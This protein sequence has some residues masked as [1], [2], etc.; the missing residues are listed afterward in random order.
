MKKTKKGQYGYIKYQKKIEIVKTI[1]MILLSVGVY[2]IGI[3]STGSNENLLTFVAVLGCLP[4]AKFCVNAIMF[5]RAKGCS[6]E[7]HE[8]LMN[9][10]LNPLYFDLYFTSAK[11]NFQVSA[12]EYKKKSLIMISEDEKID[13]TKAEEHIKTVLANCG[14]SGVTV[15]LFIEPE[16]FVQRLKELNELESDKEDITVLSDNILSVSI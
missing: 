1:F 15:K 7:L 12:L 10:N 8:R 2:R 16:K 13:V 11:S 5:S 9:E 14:Y 3:Y 4:M 6:K